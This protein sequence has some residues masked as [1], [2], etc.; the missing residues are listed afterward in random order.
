MDFKDATSSV[1][2]VL[3]PV[4]LLIF[5]E[6]G[7]VVVGEPVLSRLHHRVVDV[8]RKCRLTRHEI[9]ILHAILFARVD[10]RVVVIVCVHDLV[11]GLVGEWLEEEFDE[12]L[13]SASFSWAL[14]FAVEAEPRAKEATLT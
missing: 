1:G 12:A 6:L 4:T 11:V 8:V 3:A 13:A 7:P 5:H 10:D 14:A 2:L 9:Q